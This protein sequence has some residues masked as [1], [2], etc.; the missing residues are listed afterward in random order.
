MRALIL[1]AGILAL[2]LQGCRPAPEELNIGAAPVVMKVLE[3]VVKDF[4]DCKVN[5]NY[6][7]S[8]QIAQQVRQG[9][10]LDLLILADRDYIE[11]LAKEG[12]ILEGS[13]KVYARTSLVAWV[14]EGG[15]RLES[16]EALASITGKV[17]IANPDYTPY[18]RAATI[19][20]KASG[21]WEK[22]K[23]KL[24]YAE[25]VRH[26]VQ[27]AETKNVA[28]AI[29]PLSLVMNLKG[30]YVPIP[31]ELYIPPEQCLAIVKGT[32]NESCARRFI[33]HFLGPEGKKALEKYG[34]EVIED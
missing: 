17:A 3:E 26:A 23:D 2:I 28:A 6:A 24:V 1:F 13:I 12:F 9:A 32:K 7:A 25:D 4:K 34:F 8:G 31:R 11:T 29:V 18:G 30:H 22:V 27:L 15:P 33:S 10:P 20:L 19:A 21:L 14:P 5:I 16:F